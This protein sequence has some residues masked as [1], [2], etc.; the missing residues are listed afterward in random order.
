MPQSYEAGYEAGY[1]AG[2][3]RLERAD[4][5]DDLAAMPSKPARAD[6]ANVWAYACMHHEFARAR[7]RARMDGMTALRF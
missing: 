2:R 7:A 1:K 4:E 6:D 5:L 3:K